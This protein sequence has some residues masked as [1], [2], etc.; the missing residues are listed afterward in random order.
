MD[1]L[2][3]KVLNMVNGAGGRIPYRTVYE[4]LDSN[5][6]QQLPAVMKSLKRDGIAMNQNRRDGNGKLVF[7]IF[8]LSSGTGG[9]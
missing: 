6:K 7:E 4:A 1:Q 9:A 5:E 8:T 2:K 3:E